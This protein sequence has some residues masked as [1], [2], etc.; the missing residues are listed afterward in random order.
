MRLELFLLGDAEMLLLV[1]DQEPEI[2]ELHGLAEKRM[3]ADRDIDLAF[4]DRFLDL[5]GVLGGDQPRELLDP[6][7]QA[8]EARAEGG[9]MLAGEEGGGRHDR[10]LI[11][12][13]HRDE[14]GAQ[15]HFRLAEADIAANEAIHRLAR[16]E[17]FQR[18][19]DRAEL[20]VGLLIGEAGVEFVEQ[21]LGRHHRTPGLS[22]RSAAT[23]ISASAISRSRF[24]T[25]AFR[26]CQPCP[27]SLSSATVASS[28]P[29]RLRTSIFSTGTRSVSP[30]A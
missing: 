22:S 12:R 1:D 7:R 4:G 30:S 11:A 14:G 24:L 19:A 5:G 25:R 3:G 20:V 2:L 10:D 9:E 28:E 18:V 13:H 29:N 21:A 15:R 27:P 26:A 8:L 6:D 17:I 23:L 16:P